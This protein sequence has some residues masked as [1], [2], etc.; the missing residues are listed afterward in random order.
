VI[1]TG[2]PALVKALRF[3]R[4]LIL[5]GEDAPDDWTLRLARGLPKTEIKVHA[6]PAFGYLSEL[7]ASPT[8]LRRRIAKTLSEVIPAEPGNTTLIWHHNPALGRNLLVNEGLISFIRR[9]GVRLIAHHHDFWVENRWTRWAEMR[10][11]GFPSLSRVAEV[12]FFS[13]TSAAHATISQRDRSM[14]SAALPTTGWLP[15]PVKSQKLPMSPARKWLTK[16]LGDEAP[17]WILPTR[18]LRRKNVG[19][20]ILLTRW[21]RPDGW[22]IAAGGPS[23]KAE[24]SYTRR[25]ADAARRGNWRV[26]FDM[27]GQP[28]KTPPIHDLMRCAEAVLLTSIQEGFGLALIEAAAFQKPLIARRLANIHPDLASIGITFPHLYDDVMIPCGLIDLPAE[29]DRQ[30]RIFRDWRAALPRS[31]QRLA[32]VPQ[33]LQN[34]SDTVPFSRLTLAAQLEVLAIPPEESLAACRPSNPGWEQ[35]ENR[36]LIPMRFSAR[37]ARFLSPEAAAKRFATLASLPGQEIQ[38]S[39]ARQCQSDLIRESLNGD[40]YF[41]LLTEDHDAPS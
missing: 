33:I 15:N 32:S 14:L 22:M 27:R 6:E 30:R 3:S 8:S 39:A 36:Q 20:A 17:V 16:W 38:K 7:R 12:T 18:L 31:V 41:P 19:E 11:A 28:G 23:S 29:R 4:V 40:T 35:V 10:G 5:T 25:V 37:A 34:P 26:R 21:F 9:T 13:G 24:E 1:E 2:L